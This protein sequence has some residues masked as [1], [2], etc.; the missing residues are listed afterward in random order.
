[1]LQ[2]LFVFLTLALVI[3]SL[4]LKNGISFLYPSWQRRVLAIL[5]GQNILTALTDTFMSGASTYV[6]NFFLLFCVSALFGKVMVGN[7]RSG[8]H[9]KVADKAFGEKICDSG[10]IFLQVCY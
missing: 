9:R 5:D 7:R 2:V 1:M 10:C 8:S 3:F 6:K 4:Y